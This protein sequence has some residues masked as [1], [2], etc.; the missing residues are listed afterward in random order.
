MNE[1]HIALFR[2]ISHVAKRKKDTTQH[3]FQGDCKK[4]NV[5][6]EEQQKRTLRV[7]IENNT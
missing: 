3:D 1:F 6:K 4:V 7:R 2:Y 5:L